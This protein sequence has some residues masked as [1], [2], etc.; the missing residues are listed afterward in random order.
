MFVEKRQVFLFFWRLLLYVI[1]KAPENVTI[2]LYS[3][4]KL[5]DVLCQSSGNVWSEQ[6]RMRRRLIEEDCGCVV[7]DDSA[8]QAAEELLVT[9]TEWLAN[10]YPDRYRLQDGVLTLP[11]LGP[12]WTFDTRSLH[13]LEALKVAG[14]IAQEEI[15]LVF[16]APANDAST[17]TAE[18][19]LGPVHRFQAGVVCFSFDPMARHL[20]LMAQSGSQLLKKFVSNL[21]IPP[22][23][24]S[25]SIIKSAG[26]PVMQLAQFNHSSH[27]E[28]ASHDN[29][30]GVDDGQDEIQKEVHRPVPGYEASLRNA[31]SRVFSGLAPG[32]PLWRAN[33]ALQNSPEIIST[34]LQWHPTN[35]KLGGKVRKATLA[36]KSSMIA[37]SARW[38][39]ASSFTNRSAY[40]GVRLHCSVWWFNAESDCSV[41]RCNEKVF[42][43]FCASGCL[44]KLTACVADT[45]QIIGRSEQPPI[46][47]ECT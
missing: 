6:L 46:I 31:V 43:N 9:M 18:G 41:S 25:Q 36:T 27:H 40:F 38:H 4:E 35:I 29:H 12:D 28:T 19:S 32:R 10:R 45:L 30:P 2:H 34:D 13:G 15:C 44:R 5:V 23:S 26:Q 42:G 33:W 24:V 22:P 3:E 14:M 7:W 16:E 8:S 20:K 47:P 39:I 37:L 21:L 17:A 1:N 11:S